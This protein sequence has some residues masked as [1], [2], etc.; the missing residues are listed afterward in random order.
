MITESPIK[1]TNGE[2]K[3]MS[4][5]PTKVFRKKDVTS[6]MLLTRSPMVV[7]NS[8]KVGVVV[9]VPSGII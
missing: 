2:L 6:P 3:S 4:A 7:V 9:S 8:G 5:I 1:R